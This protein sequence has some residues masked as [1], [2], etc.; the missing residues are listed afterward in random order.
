[1]GLLPGFAPPTGN[2]N[3]TLGLALVS[4]VGYNVDWRARAGNGLFQALHGAYDE[5]SGKGISLKAGFR[6]GP[7]DFSHFFLILELSP[8]DLGRSRSLC[9]CLAI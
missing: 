2:L 8:M 3:T 4:F 9:V 5:S 7:A 1:M 6:A